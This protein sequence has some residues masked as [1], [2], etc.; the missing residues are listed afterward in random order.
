MICW[1]S[2]HSAA[3]AATVV[4]MR[5]GSSRLTPATGMISRSP[6]PLAAPPLVRR[7]AVT[8]MMSKATWMKA[9]DWRLG[10]RVFSRPMHRTP[11]ANQAPSV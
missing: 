11:V 3:I 5:F 6:A 2:T 7:S 9:W 1:P 10:Q 8:A 4:A